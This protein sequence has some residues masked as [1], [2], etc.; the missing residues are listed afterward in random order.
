M[1]SNGN[2]NNSKY[3]T[4]IYIFIEKII[5]I[6]GNMGQDVHPMNLGSYCNNP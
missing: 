5:D 4:V 2:D 6:Y 1:A 3:L